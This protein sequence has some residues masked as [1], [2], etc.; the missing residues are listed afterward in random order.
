MLILHCDFPK[1]LKIKRQGID[2][3][4]YLIFLSEKIV[5]EHSDQCY[6]LQVI[7]KFRMAK[8]MTKYHRTQILKEF[9]MELEEYK[10]NF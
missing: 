8:N 7:S 4:S 5:I 1:F 10:G 3:C 6:I 2:I 9:T